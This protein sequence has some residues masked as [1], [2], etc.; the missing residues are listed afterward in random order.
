MGRA[1]ASWHDAGKRFPQHFVLREAKQALGRGIPGHD[2]TFLVND[3][4]GINGKFKIKDEPLLKVL[5]LETGED[6][7]EIWLCFQNFYVITRYNHSALYAMAV[8]QLS[9]MIADEYNN[10]NLTSK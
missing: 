2:A 8:F 7:E 3:D 4:Y 5:S 9:E 6:T 10:I 1:I